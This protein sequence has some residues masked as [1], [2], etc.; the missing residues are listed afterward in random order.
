MRKITLET[1]KGSLC[2]CYRA[3]RNPVISLWKVENVPNELGDTVK[4]ISDQSVEMPSLFFL[5][6]IVKFQGK[7]N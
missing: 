1:G 7:R 5:L 4:E 6:L 3:A 2:L